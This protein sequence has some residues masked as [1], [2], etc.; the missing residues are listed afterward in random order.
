MDRN[1]RRVLAAEL[2]ALAGAAAACRAALTGLQA[3]EEAKL[4]NLPECFAVAP[5]AEGLGDSV[6]AIGDALPCLDE[7]EAQIDQM[8]DG[9]G[10][11]LAR[12]GGRTGRRYVPQAGPE[13]PGAKDRHMHIMVTSRLAG[14][15]EEEAVHQGLSKN[16]LVNRALAAMLFRQPGR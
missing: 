12:R 14:R 13:D 8:A 2:R 5:V 1:G 15:L 10:V 9:L 3:S 4:D 6:E 11:D 7:I 16:E